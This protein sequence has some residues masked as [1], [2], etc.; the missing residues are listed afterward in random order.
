MGLFDLFKKGK[1]VEYLKKEDVLKINDLELLRK[2][3]F[4][5]RYED[6]RQLAAFKIENIEAIEEQK[7]IDSLFVL[8]K[9]GKYEEY[10]NTLK[11]VNL[12]NQIDSV[13]CLEDETWLQKIAM[14]KFDCDVIGVAIMQIQDV[15]FLM[16]I[17]ALN[18]WNSS[19]IGNVGILR[20]VDF[21]ITEKI[22]IFLE[23]I[24][25]NDAYESGIRRI[26][27]VMLKNQQ[28][29]RDVKSK[30]TQFATV[31]K[32]WAYNVAMNQEIICFPISN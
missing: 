32:K 12:Y 6:V 31:P 18:K 20:L 28:L 24:K 11:K 23:D 22:R 8:A 1:S 17:I 4:D 7:N 25:D 21:E 2:I 29:V 26:A 5:N 13:S 16:K 27:K 9:E 30:Y 19:E 15:N 14:D 3:R 10:I